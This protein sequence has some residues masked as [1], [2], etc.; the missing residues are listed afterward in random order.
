MKILTNKARCNHCNQVIESKH[1]HDFVACNGMH[2]AVD[3][4]KDYLRRVFFKANVDWTD[5]SKT[6]EKVKM[7]KEGAELRWP[8]KT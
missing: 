2:M 7:E 3:G 8:A 6:K 4:G 5:L 1:T